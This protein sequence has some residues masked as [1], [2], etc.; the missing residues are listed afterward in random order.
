MTWMSLWDIPLLA[1]ASF[2]LARLWFRGSVFDGRREMMLLWADDRRRLRR[3]IGELLTCP[4]CL[5]AQ[6]VL[7]LSVLLILPRSFLP[8]PWP[9]VLTWALASLAALALIPLDSI[10]EDD[11]GL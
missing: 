10:K 1:A 7:W 2:A 6:L 3:K 8:L 4:I 11:D 5:S 9:E